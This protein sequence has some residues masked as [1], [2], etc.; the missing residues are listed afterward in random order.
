MCNQVIFGRY[1]S[2]IIANVFSRRNTKGFK[3]KSYD[4]CKSCNP[5]GEKC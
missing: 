2:S 1:N 3:F 5:I 4:L